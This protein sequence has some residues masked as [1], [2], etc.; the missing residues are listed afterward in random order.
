MSLN[1]LAATNAR[2]FSQLNT[3]V[4]LLVP[5]GENLRCV[6]FL[7]RGSDNAVRVSSL[8]TYW[9]TLLLTTI[10]PRPFD[11]FACF[12]PPFRNLPSREA[13]TSHVGV[14]LHTEWDAKQTGEARSRRTTCYLGSIRSFSFDARVKA[15]SPIKPVMTTMLCAVYINLGS[16]KAVST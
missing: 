15:E 10:S 3:F 11:S 8:H 9:H 13:P 5:P 14:H 4:H 6:R 2:D 1:V 16:W 7:G 12:G